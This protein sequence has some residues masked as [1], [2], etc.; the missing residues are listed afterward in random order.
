MYLSHFEEE[1]LSFDKKKY[2]ILIWQKG[3]VLYFLHYGPSIIIKEAD[4]GSA[5]IKWDREDYLRKANSQLT[6]KGV[7]LEVKDDAE[8][9]L[10]KVIKS[11]FRNTRKRGNISDE[12]CE[13]FLVNR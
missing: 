8:G 4:K 13:T 2:P 1:I 10:M 7:Y 3:D 12:T 9:F 6:D 11:V 5:K